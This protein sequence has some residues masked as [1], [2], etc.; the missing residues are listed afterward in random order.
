MSE[1]NFEFRVWTSKQDVLEVSV[2]CYELEPDY[3]SKISSGREWAQLFLDDCDFHKLLKIDATKNWQIIGKA[4]IKGKYDVFGEYDENIV[5][6][7]SR[8]LEVSDECVSL[9]FPG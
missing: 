4:T 5:I 9:R 1:C 2:W 8:R 3:T 7:E 6:H